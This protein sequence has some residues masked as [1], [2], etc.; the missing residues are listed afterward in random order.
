M[1]CNYA[2]GI[3]VHERDMVSNLINVGKKLYITYGND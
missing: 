2:A 1:R 3:H